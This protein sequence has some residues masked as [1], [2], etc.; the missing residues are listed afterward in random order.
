MAL[1][2]LCLIPVIG[3]ISI[4]S[5]YSYRGNSITISYAKLIALL[6]SVINLIVSLFIYILFDNSTNQFQYVQEHYNVQLFDIYLGIDSISIYF[7]LL[8]TIIMPIALL[9]N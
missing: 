7:I 2:S 1:S 5:I 9:S 8:T 4:A 3:S 6:T